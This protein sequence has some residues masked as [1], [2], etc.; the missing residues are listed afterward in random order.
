M[1][2]DQ[3]NGILGEIVEGR[4]GRNDI[5]EEG[6]ILLDPG[7]LGRGMRITEE[8]GGFLIAVA[9]VLECKDIRELAAVV[10]EDDGEKRG[11]GEAVIQQTRL[12]VANGS[13]SGDGGFVVQQDTEHEVAEGEIE[14]HDDLATNAPD[15]QVHLNPM[16]NTILRYEFFKAIKGTPLLELGRYVILGMCPSGFELDHA[17]HIQRSNRQI[18]QM[19]M[20][21]EGRLGNGQLLR[22]DDVVEVLALADALGNDAIIFIEG[23]LGQGDAGAAFYQSFPIRLVGKPGQVFMLLQS[24]A[25][26][27]SAAVA[28]EWRFQQIRA[29]TRILR[30]GW[31][32]LNVLLDFLGNGCGVFANSLSDTLEGYAMEQAVLNLDSFLVGE[33]LAGVGLLQVWHGMTSFVFFPRLKSTPSLFPCLTSTPSS[34]VDV[35]LGIYSQT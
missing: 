23:F 3:I 11:K 18:A 30:S 35:T 12:K 5:P 34:T 16:G 28:Y 9:V 25:A 17:R 13:G 4:A 19:E 32:D 2:E 33:V 29:G 15:N 26:F 22:L 27:A 10:S 14:G 20:P 1:G 6:V 7:L 24:T 31:Y 8:E 21:I